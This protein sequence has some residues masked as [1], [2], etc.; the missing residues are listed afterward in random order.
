MF[1][2]STSRSLSSAKRAPGAGWL[3]WLE[4][5]LVGTAFLDLAW[6]VLVVLVAISFGLV[7]FGLSWLS[8]VGLGLVGLGLVGLGLVGLGLVGLGWGASP[9]SLASLQLYFSE[10]FPLLSG[11]RVLGRRCLRFCNSSQ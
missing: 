7:G 9:S 8:W 10:G 11:R 4:L 5:G 3:A 1:S 2:R 6:L